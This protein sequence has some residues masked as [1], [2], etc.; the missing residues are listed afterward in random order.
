MAAEH[1]T[2]S[3]KELQSVKTERRFEVHVALED[4]RGSDKSEAGCVNRLCRGVNGTVVALKG[5]RGTTP[6]PV[7]SQAEKKSRVGH[8]WLISSNS[9]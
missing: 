4:V 1:I 3:T 5:G 2:R 7:T 6:L 8:V 9:S